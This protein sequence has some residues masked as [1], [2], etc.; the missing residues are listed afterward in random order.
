MFCIWCNSGNQWN[1]RTQ[2]G[3]LVSFLTLNKSFTQPVT[4][5]SQQMNSIVMAMA[6][7]STYLSLIDAEPE[8]DDGYVE[9][10][11]AKEHEDG[12]L[13]ETKERTGVWAWKHPHQADG[14]ITYTNSKEMLHLMMSIL[15]IMKKRLYFIM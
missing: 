9:L 8:V 14:T 12:T 4:Q 3:T 5:I 2:L 7:V 6:G 13:E 11:N 1:L 10:V 15:D